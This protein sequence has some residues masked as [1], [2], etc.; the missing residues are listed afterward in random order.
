MVKI[1]FAQLLEQ[2][3][4]VAILDPK[5]DLTE[6]IPGPGAGAPHSERG[7]VQHRRPGIPAGS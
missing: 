3:C 1:A 2:G 6:G 7:Q 4:V 5:G